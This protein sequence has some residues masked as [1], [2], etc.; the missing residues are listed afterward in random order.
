MPG[1]PAGTFPIGRSE[2][3]GTTNPSRLSREAQLSTKHGAD[4]DATS[5]Q[6]FGP[7]TV[8][9]ADHRILRSKRFGCSHYSKACRNCSP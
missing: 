3:G 1:M 6:G 2:G 8:N 9:A 7:G 4:A 5:S